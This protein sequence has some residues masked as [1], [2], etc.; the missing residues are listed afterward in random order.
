MSAC[1]PFGVP[2]CHVQIGER[3]NEEMEETSRWANLSRYL[4]DERHSMG[5]IPWG[6]SAVRS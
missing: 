5:A 3:L 6:Y 2:H 1:D 4:L